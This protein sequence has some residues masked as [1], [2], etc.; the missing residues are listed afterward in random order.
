MALDS[1]LD[2]AKTKFGVKGDVAVTTAIA[3]AISLLLPGQI[4]FGR[5]ALALWVGLFWCVGWVRGAGAPGHWNRT[6]RV[7][8]RFGGCM[9]VWNGPVRGK[10]G[11]E[12]TQQPHTPGRQRQGLQTPVAFDHLFFYIC[13]IECTPNQAH[14]TIKLSYYTVAAH[15]HSGFAVV[16]H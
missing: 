14:D 10:G 11:R 1:L 2:E 7:V 3:V 8:G 5:A 12:A 4:S 15:R 16:T 6:I 9:G 13:E